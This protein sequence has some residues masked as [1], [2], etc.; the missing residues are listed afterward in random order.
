M[1]LV[2]S[3]TLNLLMTLVATETKPDISLSKLSNVVTV[4]GQKFEYIIGD[5]KFRQD[6]EIYR[7]CKL[8]TIPGEA[9]KKNA[10]LIK[11]TTILYSFAEFCA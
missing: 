2:L 4:V 11:R 5:D 6:Y 3:V 10:S 8:L 9:F 1:R 7:V